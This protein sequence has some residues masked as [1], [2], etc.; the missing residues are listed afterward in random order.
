MTTP[1]LNTLFAENTMKGNL[2][3]VKNLI[4]KGV[5]PNRGMALLQSASN[6][7]LSIVKFLIEK[8]ADIR[9]NFDSVI[10][11]SAQYG[12][13]DVMKYLLK[14]HAGSSSEYALQL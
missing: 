13:L 14:T 7:H 12:H 4:E 6:G 10:Q 1:S 3:E 2:D 8:G 9:T 11:Q 5:D